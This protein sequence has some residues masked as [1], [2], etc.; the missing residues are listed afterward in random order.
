MIQEIVALMS[1]GRWSEAK[2]AADKMVFSLPTSAEGHAYQGLCL[3]HEQQ[4]EAAISSFE[5]ATTLNPHYWEAGFKLAECYD[6][7]MRY[8]EAY[9]VGVRFQEIHPG[10]RS[11]NA[12][13]DGL[14]HHLTDKVTDG[15]QKSKD[16]PAHTIHFTN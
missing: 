11:F 10:D 6:R 12:F 14:S 13:V 1:Q 15:W 8:D 3:F 5:R 16:Q 7:L 2:A 4:W 9:E